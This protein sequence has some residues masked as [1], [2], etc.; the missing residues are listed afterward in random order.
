[1]NTPDERPIPPAGAKPWQSML[2][3]YYELIRQMRRSHLS[4]ADIAARLLKDHGITV[5]RSGV[6]AFVR[7]RARRR[8]GYELPVSE[9][10]PISAPVIAGAQC[11]GARSADPA[12]PRAHGMIPIKDRTYTD[13]TGREVSPPPKPF[14]PSEL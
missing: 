6:H 14:N 9:V 10:P 3:P 7:A 1:M 11:S 5:T 2:N 4:Y 12:P 13:S 8:V